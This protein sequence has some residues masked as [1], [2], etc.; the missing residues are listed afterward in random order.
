MTRAAILNSIFVVWAYQ[1]ADLCATTFRHFGFWVAALVLFF[2]FL[3][4]RIAAA[5]LRGHA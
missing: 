4:N 2:C 1:Q 5:W 3:G